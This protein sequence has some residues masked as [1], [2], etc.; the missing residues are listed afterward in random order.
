LG[1]PLGGE[2]MQLYEIAPNYG[3]KPGE[4]IGFVY[5]KS[6]Y[7]VGETFCGKFLL[8]NDEEMESFRAKESITKKNEY[9]TEDER[10]ELEKYYQDRETLE[11]NHK[12]WKVA[13][14]EK[15]VLHKKVM[16]AKKSRRLRLV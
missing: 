11:E 12:K 3:G 5:A 2:L 1:E 13:V 10:A 6:R 14:K 9:L 15:R 4:T 7:H 16:K 8:M